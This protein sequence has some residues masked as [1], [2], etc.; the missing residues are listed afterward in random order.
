MPTD[1]RVDAYIADQADFARPILLHLRAA[2]HDACP[3]CEEAIKW[4]M[5]AF[6]YRGKQIAGMAAFKSHATF[7]FRQAA[8]VIEDGGKPGAMGQFGRLTSIA[9]LPASQELE[10]LVRAA[11]A[12]VES[13][14]GPARA[15]TEKPPL[16]AAA[17]LL[18][19]LAGNPAACATFSAFP[20]GSRRDY[21]EWVL[22][23][24]RPDTRA[25]RIAQA[26]EWIADGKKRN[27]KYEGC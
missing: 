1:P 6:T 11:M 3:G 16:E 23:A 2:I 19:A 14:A 7:G 27:W 12:Y 10:R 17:D 8:A 26:V 22:D 21:V 25:R 15:R 4:G 20:P 9:D 5:P 18:D 13:D 24:K